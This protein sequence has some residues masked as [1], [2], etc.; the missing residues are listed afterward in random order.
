MEM[1]TSILFQ[2]LK[3]KAGSSNSIIHENSSILILL[4][5][6]TL[7]LFFFLLKSISFGFFLTIILS[8]LNWSHNLFSLI[9]L[10]AF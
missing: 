10:S 3:D 4:F 5:Q 7:A 1:D 8:V 6:L 2:C 9:L